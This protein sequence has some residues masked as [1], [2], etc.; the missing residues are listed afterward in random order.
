MI[1]PKIR[2]YETFSGWRRFFKITPKDYTS[3]GLYNLY[4]TETVINYK[5]KIDLKCYEMEIIEEQVNL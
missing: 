3:Y 2:Q 5:I 4:Q 1:L